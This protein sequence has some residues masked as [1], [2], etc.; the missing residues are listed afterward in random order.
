M[1]FDCA[2]RWVRIPV[3]RKAVEVLVTVSSRGAGSV[4][5][6]DRLLDVLQQHDCEIAELPSEA[7]ARPSGPA[8]K[9]AHRALRDQQTTED[10]NEEN[11]GNGNKKSATA[12][13]E[14]RRAGKAAI[15]GAGGTTCCDTDLNSHFDAPHL[16]LLAAS[17]S[18]GSP[19]EEHRF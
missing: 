3:P 1:T 5:W 7:S 4:E 11:E 17:P 15:N 9:K 12:C 13:F 18:S 16:P 6:L 2:S 19:P 10:D 14:L 8:S